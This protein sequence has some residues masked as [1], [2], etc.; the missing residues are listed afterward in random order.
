MEGCFYGTQSGCLS[1][2]D[3]QVLKSPLP[4]QVAVGIEECM[5]YSSTMCLKHVIITFS[6]KLCSIAP[7]INALGNVN[8]LRW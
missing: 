7:S 8:V 3:I 1:H 4:L 2:V 6:S 5:A